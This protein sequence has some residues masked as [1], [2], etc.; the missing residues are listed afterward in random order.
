[1]FQSYEEM[2]SPSEDSGVEVNHVFN[3]DQSQTS[4]KTSSVQMQ[5]YRTVPPRLTVDVENTTS[6][7]ME[8]NR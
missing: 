2:R 4:N 5:N 1:M 8:N 3:S 6:K 7:I